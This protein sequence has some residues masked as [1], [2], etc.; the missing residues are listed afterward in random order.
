M[1]NDLKQSLGR[2]IRALRNARGLNQERL[3]EMIGRSTETVSNIERGRTLPSLPTLEG[4]ARSLGISLAELFETTE[5]SRNRQ[6]LD[7]EAEARAILVS[8]SDRDLEIAVKQLEALA[9]GKG[10]PDKIG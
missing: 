5:G 3:A 2:Q 4:L 7:L 10:S 8:L 9:S 1:A 6:R